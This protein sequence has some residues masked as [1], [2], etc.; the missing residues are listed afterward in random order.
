MYILI[1]YKED[2]EE[3]YLS[4]NLKSLEE[5]CNQCFLENEYSESTY[6]CKIRKCEVTDKVIN[7]NNCEVI[8][9]VN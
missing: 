8:L 1:V 7:L 3:Y 5:K 4:N 9:Q 2:K 6:M